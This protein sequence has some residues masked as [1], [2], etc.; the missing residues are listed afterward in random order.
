MPYQVYSKTEADRLVQEFKA[1]KAEIK[2]LGESKGSKLA[3]AEKSKTLAGK[4]EAIEA[5]LKEQIA[6]CRT[7]FIQHAQKVDIWLGQCDGFYKSGAKALEDFKKFGRVLDRE[8]ALG[9]QGT[10][11]AV[12]KLAKDDAM[13]YGVSWKDFRSA[14]FT[15][16]GLN[17]NYAEHFNN[18]VGKLVAGQKPVNVKIDKMEALV[19]QAGALKK[20]VQKATATTVRDLGDAREEADE[21]DKKI[22]ALFVAFK[23]ADK[24][25]LNS[26]TTNF[27]SL[28]KAAKDLKI[29]KKAA[30]KNYESLYT[31]ALNSVKSWKAG[32]KG[33]DGVLT[34]AKKGFSKT[35][36]ADAAVKKSL[37]EADKTMSEAR[38][39][40][41]N[42]EL[43]LQQAAKDVAVLRKR[44]VK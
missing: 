25:G 27:A 21:L 35:E 7:N 19:E 8:A 42:G 11:Q 32:Y 44:L 40:I 18:E 28:G 22:A 17:A 41:K 34:T 24:G 15:A 43:G 9:C 4:G 39:V 33:M 1:L 12:L 38:Y 2:K 20:L 37:M 3:I 29:N 14:N 23:T 16:G 6:G 10:I 5:L 31:N 30:L 13:D 36:L 26:V